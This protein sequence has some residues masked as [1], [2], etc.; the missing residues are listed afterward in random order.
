LLQL[1]MFFH[2]FLCFSFY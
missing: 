1:L 2:W